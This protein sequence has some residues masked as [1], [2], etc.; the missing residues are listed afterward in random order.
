MAVVG[1]FLG[2]ATGP[3]SLD[4]LRGQVREMLRQGWQPPTQR[5]LVRDDLAAAVQAALVPA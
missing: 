4:P 1:P 2:M 3:T 5:D